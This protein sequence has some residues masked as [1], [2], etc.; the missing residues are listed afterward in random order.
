METGNTSI[1]GYLTS[2]ADAISSA[3]PGARRESVENYLKR[4]KDLEDIA[5]SFK[6]VEKSYAIQAGREIRVI[7]QPEKI[8][9]AQAAVMARDITNRPFSVIDAG[10]FQTSPSLPDDSSWG[11]NMNTPN[12]K[13]PDMG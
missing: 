11:D 10:W 6:G 7:V 2:A 13:F 4:L 9:D 8:N 3:R 12:K 1:W 5:N